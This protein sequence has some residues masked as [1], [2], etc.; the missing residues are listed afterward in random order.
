[1]GFT[2]GLNVKFRGCSAALANSSKTD[3]LDDLLFMGITALYF[4]L[5]LFWNPPKYVPVGQLTP[6]VQNPGL[7]EPDEDKTVPR[8]GPLS[9]KTLF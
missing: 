4:L 2:V 5:T 8:T 3:T 7:Y 1:M 9:K 6:L